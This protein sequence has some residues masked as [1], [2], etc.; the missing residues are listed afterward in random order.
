MT[1]N[2]SCSN[3]SSLCASIFSGLDKT[4]LDSWDDNKTSLIF[5]K[6]QSLFL[7]GSPPNGIFCI[8]SGL[9]KVTQMGSDGKESIV[10]LCK[11]GDT[12]GHRSLFSQQTYQSS[13]TAIELTKICFFDKSFIKQI[14][15]A[16]PSVAFNMINSL[17]KDLGEAEHKISSFSHKNVKQRLAELIL[18]LS[19]SYGQE[20]DDGRVKISVILKRDEMASMIGTASETLIR[21]LAELKK[22]NIIEQEG[23]NIYILDHQKLQVSAAINL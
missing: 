12:V 7:Q 23:K 22:E 6:G 11:P 15:A 8:K 9:V 10:R 19:D 5:K 17:G 18:S 21:F 13:A 16:E 3:C 14:I 20:Q 4:K 2:N 1:K